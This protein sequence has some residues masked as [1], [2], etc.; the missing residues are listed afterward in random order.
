M[1]FLSKKSKIDNV[2]LVELINKQLE[3]HDVSYKDIRNDSE[4][5]MKYATSKEEQSRFADWAVY[6]LIDQLDI[7]NKR[8]EEE[9]SWFILEY[10]LPIKKQKAI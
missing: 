8:A 5:F 4:W 3:P 9:V 1:K 2:M 10:G 6:Y 7:S